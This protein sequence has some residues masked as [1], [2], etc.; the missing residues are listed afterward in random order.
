[1]VK[2]KSEI[3]EQIQ[4]SA[5]EDPRY[6]AKLIRRIEPEIK[7]VIQYLVSLDISLQ[8]MCTI[9]CYYCENGLDNFEIKGDKSV[10]EAFKELESENEAIADHIIYCDFANADKL[11]TLTVLY[12]IFES[13]LEIRRLI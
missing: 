7:K 8:D 4:R 2:I 5:I 6:L 13:E 1:M 12:R 10:E 3:L 11:V 9:F